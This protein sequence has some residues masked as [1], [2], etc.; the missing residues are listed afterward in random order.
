MTTVVVRGTGDVGSAVAHALFNAGYVVVMHDSAAPAHSRRGMAFADCIF[1]GTAELEGVIA[2]RAKNGS[3]LG[4]MLQCRKAV[5]VSIAELQTLIDVARPDVV[6]DARMRKRSNPERQIGLAPITI[7]LGPNHEAG[8][9][10]DVVAETAHSADLGHVIK[11]GRT[12]DLAGEPQVIGGHGRE[13][14]VYAP[15][16]GVFETELEIGDR[17]ERGSVIGHIGEEE[18]LAPIA[19]CL[20]GLTRSGIPVETGAKVIEVDARGLRTEVFGLG[21]RPQIIARGVLQAIDAFF[22]GR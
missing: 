21:G 7:G 14:F 18:L 9:T 19:G 22:P 3:A 4:Y 12:K 16:L 2:R 1:D 10:T 15:V 17:V 5:A 6:I 20:R 8:V 13:R 11:D